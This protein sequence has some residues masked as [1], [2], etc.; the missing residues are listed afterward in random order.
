MLRQL[1]VS[2]GLGVAQAL[3]DVP[4]LRLTASSLSEPWQRAP[5]LWPLVPLHQPRVSSAPHN[6]L[7]GR[8]LEV[9]P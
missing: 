1:I 9:L 2:D 3:H 8:S 4:H 7:A 6:E 5:P